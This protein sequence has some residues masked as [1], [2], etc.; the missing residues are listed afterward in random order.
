MYERKLKKCNNKAS[1]VIE[2]QSEQKKQH[3]LRH[4]K[5]YDL[6]SMNLDVTQRHSRQE[7]ELRYFQKK[8]NDSS[9]KK[10]KCYNCNVEEHYANECRKSKKL[11]QVART[12]KRSK[13]QKQK[14]ATVLTVLFSKH[15][16]DCLSWTACYNNTCI[17]H[18]SDK[19]DSE[20]FSKTSRKMQQLQVTEKG[21]KSQLQVKS[22][23]EAH[24]VS[25]LLS[26]E[27]G[28]NNEYIIMKS[29]NSEEEYEVIS[30][31]SD[32]EL[33][34]DQKMSSSVTANKFYSKIQSMEKEYSLKLWNAAYEN[35]LETL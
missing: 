22:S 9:I 26:S 6:Q 24:T 33:S 19:D 7:K 32:D 31:S 17:T 10:G 16:H 12:E 27:V 4:Y 13:Q 11:Q 35:I 18:W 28:Q 20:W 29:F 5:D 15:E 30:F 14:L 21:K 25:Q 34:E 23:K 1:I 8:E 2:E 3:T